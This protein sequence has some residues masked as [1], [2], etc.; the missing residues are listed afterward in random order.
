MKKNMLRTE[1][2]RLR[3]TLEIHACDYRIAAQLIL[4][5]AQ[6]DNSFFIRHDLHYTFW[7]PSQNDKGDRCGGWLVEGEEGD[8]SEREE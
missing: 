3:S 5:F 6:N 4:R 2:P 7:T 8:S 1:D